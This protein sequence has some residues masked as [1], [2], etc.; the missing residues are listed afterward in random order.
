[1]SELTPEQRECLETA[2]ACGNSL[3]RILGDILDLAKISAGKMEFVDFPFLITDALQEVVDILKVVADSKGIDLSLQVDPSVTD[4]VVGDEGR[5]RQAVLNLVGNALKFTERGSVRIHVTGGSVVDSRQEV[6]VAVTDT[7]IGIAKEDQQKLFQAFSQV[8]GSDT[9]RFGGT[10]LGLSLTKQ[11]VEQM[12]GT[13]GVSSRKGKG[14]SFFFTIPFPLAGCSER[15]AE[16]AEHAAAAPAG[17]RPLS[18]LIADDDPLIREMVEMAFLKRH[19]RVITACNGA[20]AV[21]ECERNRFDAILL[22]VQM[23][24]MDGMKAA[25]AIR[26]RERM[27]GEHTP[28]IAVTARA[29]DTDGKSCE[30]AGMDDCVTK[31]F[32]FRNLYSVIEKHTCAQ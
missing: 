29:L 13:I 27:R 9:R 10:G 23:P 8:D 11:I 25:R 6:T 4:G 12:G 22:D 14:S 16:T 32:N 1:D 18:I 3:V 28:L 2:L 17:E 26:E 24:V 20:E 21:A 7:G 19:W 31:P 30:E 15:P 5:L